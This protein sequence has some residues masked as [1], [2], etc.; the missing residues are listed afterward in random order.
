MFCST[1]SFKSYTW[2]DPSD[3]TWDSKSYVG[4]HFTVLLQLFVVQLCKLLIAIICINFVPRKMSLLYLPAGWQGVDCSLLCSSGLWGLGCNQSCLCS[5][6]AAC[7]PMEGTCT[8]SP[9]WRGEHC[10][11]P[12]PVS[13]DIGPVGLQPFKRSISLCPQ[14]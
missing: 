14:V 11:E 13:Q 10:D 5:N 9:G 4:N 1:T 12:C 8:C 7:D 6:G 2:I 3:L